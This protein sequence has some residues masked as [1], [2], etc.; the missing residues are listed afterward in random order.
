MDTGLYGP[1]AGVDEDYIQL[2]NRVEGWE[3]RTASPG[4][5]EAVPLGIVLLASFGALYLVYYAWKKL[6]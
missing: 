2:T 4:V 5:G 1:G 6:R 3:A